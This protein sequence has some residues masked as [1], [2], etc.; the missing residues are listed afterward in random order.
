MYYLKKINSELNHLE[1]QV[2]G[3]RKHGGH[4][5][6]KS[7]DLLAYAICDQGSKH[8]I[9]GIIPG[10][11]LEVNDEVVYHSFSGEKEAIE[12]NPLGGFYADPNAV[13]NGTYLCITMPNYN[14]PK[15]SKVDSVIDSS[16]QTD[17]IRQIKN[18]SPN[19][20]IC[21]WNEYCKLRN[22]L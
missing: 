4:I 1:S 12:L 15:S 9:H 21:D 14:N 5:F 3:R 13:I 16:V 11:L 18:L 19:Q 2:K 17:L 20:K 6:N 8:P 7:T 22:M 10:R